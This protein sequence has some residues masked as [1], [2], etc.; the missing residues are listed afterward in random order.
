MAG[1]LARAGVQG[2][3]GQEPLVEHPRA[4]GQVHADASRVKTP[5]GLVWMALARMLRT[6]LWLTGAVS[7]HRALPLIRRLIERGRRCARPR[8]LLCCTEGL[9]SAVRAM[10]AT[11]R[12]PERP[13]AQGRPRLRPGRHG[14]IAQ[15][16]KR[17]EQRPVV[18]VERR[19][20]AGTPAR[21]D[22][23]QA[24]LAR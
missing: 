5:G 14:F 8:P 9:R 17:D 24:S 23:A 12:E 20:V 13:G 16:G 22:S 21:V 7:P 3:A 19:I 11:L 4:L 2:Q 1:W 18:A 10:R 6:R 15:V